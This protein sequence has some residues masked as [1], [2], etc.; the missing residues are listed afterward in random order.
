VLGL[1]ALIILIKIQ[2][3]TENYGALELSE[4][5]VEGVFDSFS[6]ASLGSKIYIQLNFFYTPRCVWT[7]ELICLQVWKCPSEVVFHVPALGNHSA[8]W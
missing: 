5:L 1:F 4:L 3:S 7:G 2:N 6:C 8:S